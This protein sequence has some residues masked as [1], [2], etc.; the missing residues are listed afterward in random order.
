MRATSKRLCF[1]ASMALSNR[2]LSGCFD[3]TPAKGLTDFLLVQPTVSA[4]TTP[5]TAIDEIRDDIKPSRYTCR[6]GSLTRLPSEARR[7]VL[8]WE[9]LPQPGCARR[10]GLRPGP[11][12]SAAPLPSLPSA[13]P[14]HSSLDHPSLDHR[15]RTPRCL[16]PGFLR[17]PAP[18][19]PLSRAPPRHPLQC[20]RSAGVG[21]ESQLIAASCA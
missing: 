9:P 17:P 2:T 7:L 6:A 18:H 5:R 21:C 3:P 20:G 19:R 10:P 14:L 1:I 11:T 4:S 15:Y 16:P 12:P 8:M 13:A